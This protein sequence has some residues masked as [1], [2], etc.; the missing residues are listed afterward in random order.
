MG[1]LAEEA[2]R[3]GALGITTSRT[4]KHR[5]R[6]GRY[7]PS[8]TAAEPELFAIAGALRRAGKGVLEVNSDFG[9]GDF[10]I[11]RMA[12]EAAG[13]PMSL[14]L[15]QVDNAPDLWRRTLDQ[16]HAARRAGLDVT[17][18]VG[19]K[20]IGVLFGLETSRNPFENHPAFAPLLPLAPRQRYE[21]L[22]DDAA[23]RQRL[24]DERPTDALTRWFDAAFARTFAMAPVL[25]YEPAPDQSLA[26][27]AARS[28]GTAW[29]LALDTL[30]AHEGKGLLLHPFENY[31]GGDLGVV[32]QM[33]A[34]PAT[35]MGLGD[36]GAHVGL[37]C[38]GAG[39]TFLLKHWARDRTRGPRLPLE[40]L[41]KKQTQ[42]TAAVYGLTDR[43]T[44][45]PGQ[46]ADINVIDFATLDLLPPEVAYDLPTGGRRLLQ[47]A[48]GYRH[49]FV[50][51]TEVLRDD[52]LTGATPGRLIRG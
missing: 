46:R 5:A 42:D 48:R 24:V 39:P 11:L 27:R 35:V 33:L 9:D 15:L 22:R 21:R 30:L 34:D 51:G 49:T 36:A 18:Q 2:L 10:E 50:A 12:A 40:A 14:L 28:G 26:A 16:I 43:G 3:A 41:V 45:A 8:L 23:L 20:S 17:G 13:R 7:T 25:D 31:T 37:I 47:R 38:D 29:A 44:L 4:T 52:E 32:Q 1:A 6:D 19:A